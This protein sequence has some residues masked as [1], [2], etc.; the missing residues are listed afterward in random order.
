MKRILTI[1]LILYATTAFSQTGMMMNRFYI[2]GSLVLGKGD[3]T[4]ADTSCWLQIGK[5]TT[6]KGLILPRVVLDSVKTAKRGLFVYDLKDSV[7]YHFDANKRVRYM[8]YKDTVI[9]KQLIAQNAPTIDTN[10]IS[11]KYFVIN[12]FIK[13]GGNATGSTLSIGTNDNQQVN[14]KTNN[15]NRIV[16]ANDGAVG[17]GA[18]PTI[19][20]LHVN[21]KIGADGLDLISN[22]SGSTM[23]GI[24]RNSTWGTTVN[25]AEGS[26]SDYTLINNPTNGQT[27][28]TVPH[29]TNKSKFH[30]KVE[31][32]NSTEEVQVDLS[33]SPSRHL[34]AG[35]STSTFNG[36]NKG[37]VSFGTT[38]TST[39]TA[40]IFDSTTMSVPNGNL[41]VGKYANNGVDKLQVAGTAQTFGIKFN[42]SVSYDGNHYNLIRRYQDTYTDGIEIVSG[43]ASGGF[44]GGFR[45]KTR[46]AS[47]N[48]TPIES[49]IINEDK[50]SMGYH[51]Q[52]LGDGVPAYVS[53]IN[54]VSQNPSGQILNLW[55]RDLG[56]A[57]VQSFS[58][59]TYGPGGPTMT[60]AIVAEAYNNTYLGNLS[61]FTN[62]GTWGDWASNT[63]AMLID[64]YQNVGIGVSRNVGAVKDGIG[65]TLPSARL[66]VLA[67][68]ASTPVTIFQSASS[69]TADLTQWKDNSGTV[70]A[71]F[72]KDGNATVQKL[73]TS[74]PSSNGAGVYKL[75]KVITG[76][77]V[78]LQTD[79]FVEVEIDG[80]IYKLAIVE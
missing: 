42:N 45:I 38:N 31:V 57:V 64:G 69:Q 39:N 74:Q 16:V 56:G 17:I 73:K 65:L 43:G 66:H 9:I 62:N 37:F 32:N 71:K 33:S 2:T 70:L 78:T 77:S 40:L 23:P 41:L 8:T 60:A 80:A 35:V 53:Q 11:T 49:F 63:R 47:G 30:G 68:N 7:L 61:L 27:V 34:Y 44:N 48:T 25:G 26:V 79:K 21:G 58:N 1:L 12:G 10:V 6:N 18:S 15:T 67:S 46:G 50:I 55:N 28:M 52:Y 4:F 72:D 19:G 36:S 75:G 3:R 24:Y 22:S 59:Y 5:D 51:T 20:K 29:G 76:A 54:M 13:I 14:I